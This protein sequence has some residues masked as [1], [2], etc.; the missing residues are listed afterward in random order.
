MKIKS[1]YFHILRIV[2]RDFSFSS[3]RNLLFENLS[4]VEPKEDIFFKWTSVLIFKI[5]FIMNPDKT[6]LKFIYKSYFNE[7]VPHR[8][9]FFDTNS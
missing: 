6:F 2:L 1:I 9:V 7:R 5:I 4:M 3:N 8:V